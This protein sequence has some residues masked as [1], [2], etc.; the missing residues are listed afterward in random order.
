MFAIKLEA[1][2][3]GSK[4]E[5]AAWFVQAFDLVGKA[6]AGEIAIRRLRFDIIDSITQ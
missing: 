2:R 5:K 1:G 6:P 3:I 4:K